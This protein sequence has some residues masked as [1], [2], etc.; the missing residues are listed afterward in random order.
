MLPRVRVCFFGDS[1]TLGVGDPAGVGWVGRITAAARQTG[2]DLTAYNLGVRRD[3]ALDVARRWRDEARVRLVDGEPAGVVF[4]VGTNDIALGHARSRTLAVLGD[5][6]GGCRWPAL[7]VGPPP[8]GA[9]DETA[10]ARELGAGMAEL[11]VA[12]GVPYVDVLTPLEADPVWRQE[13][14]AGDAY[15]PSARGYERFA[16]VVSGPLLPWLAR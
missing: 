12:R 9:E 16:G 11:C 7:V 13:V 1:L 10:R 4:A 5:L 3:T 14:A 15:H 8:V 2:R 6:L